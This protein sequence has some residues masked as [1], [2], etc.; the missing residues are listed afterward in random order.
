MSKNPRHELTKTAPS[1]NVN[2]PKSGIVPSF[3]FELLL[4]PHG[5]FEPVI[6]EHSGE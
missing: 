2:C 4:R 5:L 3:V 6:F 1:Y